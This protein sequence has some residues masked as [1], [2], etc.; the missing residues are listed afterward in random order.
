LLIENKKSH[1]RL[2]KSERSRGFNPTDRFRYVP[3]LESVIVLQDR[4]TFAVERNLCYT[5][6]RPPMS[7]YARCATQLAR[8]YLD[9]LQAELV[10]NPSTA[11]Q[12]VPGGLEQLRP[13]RN[14]AARATRLDVDAS[15]DFLNNDATQVAMDGVFRNAKPALNE[16]PIGVVF[17]RALDR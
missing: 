10:G 14:L 15:I 11:S 17:S 9:S 6:D 7:L 13:Q 4:T 3:I 12:H 1:R 2:R 8:I 16:R 5:L